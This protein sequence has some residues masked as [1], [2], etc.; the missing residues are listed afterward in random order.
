[1]ELGERLDKGQLDRNPSDKQQPGA[2]HD[3]A[4][5]ANTSQGCHSS[6]C[7]RRGDEEQQRD[8]GK[9]RDCRTEV[10]R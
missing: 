4:G 9:D 3:V 7:H 10:G 2:Y 6:Y 8:S 1:M 5:V